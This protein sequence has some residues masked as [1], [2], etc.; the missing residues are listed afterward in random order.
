MSGCSSEGEHHLDTV[1][2]TGSIPVSRTMKKTAD[3]HVR[4]RFL[5]YYRS[6]YG[7]FSHAAMT[8]RLGKRIFKVSSISASPSA[9]YC[10]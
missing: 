8:F 2:A 7:H 4:G 6:G 3:A 1:G 9:Q 10:Q 5:L